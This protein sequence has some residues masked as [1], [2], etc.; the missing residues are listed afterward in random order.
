MEKFISGE[1]KINVKDKSKEELKAEAMK[2]F[3]NK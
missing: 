3:E 2:E 1:I